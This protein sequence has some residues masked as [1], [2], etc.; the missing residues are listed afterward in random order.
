MTL[1]IHRYVLPFSL[2]I[3]GYIVKHIHFL[4]FIKTTPH[5]KHT[6]NSCMMYNKNVLPLVS[7]TTSVNTCINSI[8]LA[9][10]V[11]IVS[12]EEEEMK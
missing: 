5:K 12:G 6:T 1:K 2:E 8:N 10:R 7:G 4:R 9:P 11:R 3:I